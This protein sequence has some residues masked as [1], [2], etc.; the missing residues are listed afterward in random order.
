MIRGNVLIV[1]GTKYGQTARIA[2]RIR[3]VLNE[4]DYDVTLRAADELP[5][6]L[7][8]SQFDATIV[9]ASMIAGKYQKSVRKFVARHRWVLNRVPSAFFAVSGAAG[10]TNPLE[11]EEA[12]HRMEQFCRDAGWHPKL[13]LSVA[14]AIAYTKYGIVTRWVMTR[15]SRK[16]GRS[17]DTSRDHEYTDWVQVEQFA[18]RFADR[19]D[20]WLR[21]NAVALPAAAQAAA[22]APT[23][24]ATPE[25]LAPAFA[26]HESEREPVHA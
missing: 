13:A 23:A 4:R 24:L 15:V 16:E 14:G 7:C 8:P 3:N 6:G 10:S 19:M 1:Y 9:G 20:E 12:H 21:R 26:N 11:R 25:P 2:A 22:A 17:T 18:D 5:V